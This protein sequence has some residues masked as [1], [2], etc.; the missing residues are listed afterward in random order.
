M[1]PYLALA[2]N[3]ALRY[4]QVVEQGR[5]VLAII[6][7]PDTSPMASQ[8]TPDRPR[9]NSNIL[10]LQDMFL[11]RRPSERTPT[12]TATFVRRCGRNFA[13]TANHVVNALKGKRIAEETPAP[14]LGMWVGSTALNFCRITARGIVH[15]FRAAG[16]TVDPDF[17]IAIAPLDDFRSSMLFERDNRE[18]INLDDWMEP[19]WPQV[20]RALAAGYPTHHKTIV[21][22]D[23]KRQL[24]ATYVT[25]IFQIDPPFD[26]FRSSFTLHREYETEH[27]FWFSGLSGGPVYAIEGALDMVDDTMLRP[28]G[29]V[30]QGH[31]GSPD[32][33][34][35]AIFTTKHAVI[36]ALMLTPATF[37][38]WLTAAGLKR[39]ET[40][41]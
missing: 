26:P 21:E 15:S 36:H 40:P 25:P 3:L 14:A 20:T 17:D 5:V 33:S 13:V 11:R 37:D 1:K 4:S 41:V 38:T 32:A 12:A 19:D 22:R 31:P 39:S 6:S 16:G 29:I 27:G 10:W 2:G 8:P 24:D 30:T 18:A 34:K 9:R 23:G 7:N 35:S 28:M